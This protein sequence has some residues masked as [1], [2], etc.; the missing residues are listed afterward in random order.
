MTEPTPFSQYL[1]VERAKRGLTGT[2]KT[3]QKT[4]STLTPVEAKAQ[5]ESQDLWGRI[6]SLLSTGLYG[7][8]NTVNQ[9][10]NEMQ[11]QAERQKQGEQT[12]LEDAIGAAGNVLTAKWRGQ[13]AALANAFGTG[14]NPDDMVGGAQLIEKGTDAFG[15]TYNRDYKDETNNVNPVAAGVG[16]FAIDVAADPFTWIPGAQVAKVANLGAR[17]IKA[18]LKIPARLTEEAAIKAENAMAAAGKAGAEV[19]DEASA[20]A[21]PYLKTDVEDIKPTVDETAAAAKVSSDIADATD[22]TIPKSPKAPKVEEAKA[23]AAVDA[24]PSF[25]ELLSGMATTRKGGLTMVQDLG[26]RANE[27]LSGKANKAVPVLLKED[28]WATALT[29]NVEAQIAGRVK[30]GAGAT[31]ATAKLQKLVNDVATNPAARAS[32]YR[33][34]SEGFAEHGGFVDELG[35]KQEGKGPLAWLK[36]ASNSTDQNVAKISVGGSEQV[37]KA[38]DAVAAIS[39]GKIG[40][41]ALSAEQKSS[42]MEQV[43]QAF[44]KATTATDTSV[45]SVAKQ[46]RADLKSR[47]RWYRDTVG[48]KLYAQLAKT[49]DDTK[50]VAVFETLRDVADG[51]KSISKLLTWAQEP[52]AS[53]LKNLFEFLGLPDAVAHNALYRQAVSNVTDEAFKQMTKGAIDAKDYTAMFARAGAS[54]DQ[55]RDM[56]RVLGDWLNERIAMRDLPFLTKKGATAS[57]EL[58]GEGIRFLPS[59][60]NSMDMRDLYRDINKMAAKRA[61]SLRLF[62]KARADAVRLY[63]TEGMA[64]IEHVMDTM[65]FPLWVSTNIPVAQGARRFLLSPTQIMAALN[66]ADSRVANM[67]F[68]NADTKVPFTFVMDAIIRKMN[69]PAAAIDDI[70]DGSADAA[71]WSQLGRSAPNYGGNAFVSGGAYGSAGKAKGK[72]F[73]GE[74][75]SAMFT[76]ALDNSLTDLA[77]LAKAND[78]AF[79]GRWPSESKNLVDQSWERLNALAADPTRI[80]Q[81]LQYTA[82]LMQDAA[83]NGKFAGA[84]DVSIIKAQEQ[85]R[86]LV[87]DASMVFAETSAR[88]ASKAKSSMKKTAKNPK[89]TAKEAD[90][91]AA[92]EAAPEVDKGLEKAID[93]YDANSQAIIDEI[94]ELVNASDEAIASEKALG[95]VNAMEMAQLAPFGRVWAA[96]NSRFNRF[97]EMPHVANTLH[98]AIGYAGQL[99]H[100]YARSLNAIAKS[101]AKVDGDGK[102]VLARVFDDIRKG[103]TPTVGDE[104]AYEQLKALTAMVHDIGGKGSF[105]D[106]PL[107]RT[108]RG[109]E[110]VSSYLERAGLDPI[111]MDLAAKAV[112]DGTYDNLWDAASQQWREAKIADP[113]DYL[114][115]RQSALMGLV[116][117]VS[118]AK[119]FQKFVKENGFISSVKKPGYVSTKGMDGTYFQFLPDDQFINAELVQELQHLSKYAEQSRSMGGPLGDFVN[120]SFLPVQNAWKKAIT[121]YRPGHHIRNLFGTQSIIFLAEGT[122]G[123]APSALAARKILAARNNYEGVDVLKALMD[124]GVKGAGDGSLSLL[125]VGG[126]AYTADQAWRSMNRL[127]LMPTY[128][129]GE[130]I[131]EGVATNKIVKAVEKVSLKDT[132]F[133]KVAGGVS[134]Y[135]D[136]FGRAHQ[137]M[138]ILTQNAKRVGAGKKFKTLEDLEKYA[139]D[140]VK[141]FQ[142]DSSM[143]TPFEAKYLRTAIPFYSWFRGVLPAMMASVVMTPGRFMAFPKASFN[144]AYAMGVNPDSLYDPFPEDQ[145]FPS[146]LTEQIQGPVFDI[147]GSYIGLNPGIASFDVFNTLGQDPIRGIAG[148]TTPLVRA[149][150]E[151]LT[152]SQVSTGARIKD[153]SDYVDSQIPGVNYLSNITGTSAS[154]SLLSLLQGKGFDPQ[155]Q[156]AAG[157]KTVG[158]Q[159]VS[160]VNYL[161]GLG[162]Q[163]MSKPNYIN[164]AEIERRNKAAEASK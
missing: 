104:A 12:T 150:I 112:K 154:G 44:T 89:A 22:V 121:I 142:P 81:A 79:V 159:G 114:M 113:M 24:V 134:E 37:L 83:A 82:N 164:Y 27:L 51:E 101:F 84:F 59:E 109:V 86:K 92:K 73:T 95:R 120:N 151:M 34:Y 155:Y 4:I 88:G 103:N 74:E 156:V 7:M 127:G 68:F 23:A 20:A 116:K 32:L 9:G 124:D 128:H 102:D 131:A 40:K 138:M 117:D 71:Y 139:A 2:P 132:K 144:L 25:D 163:N 118:V 100:E 65:G 129:V 21:H 62:G 10:F 67:L 45:G 141:K 133:E 160:L 15:Q 93:E 97:H 105:M 38:S 35:R 49:T 161:T 148:M 56:S 125:N 99:R 47:E 108:Q 33:R 16:G 126:K 41:E 64:Y 110:T 85:L 140:R 11:K 6:I 66:A 98:E 46:I 50:L 60:L 3:Q 75:I 90:Q 30:T 72:K 69:D 80:G 152:G 53:Q 29:K 137:Y 94:P 55:A 87:P 157:N 61:D 115:R 162:I 43:T 52:S 18:A 48:S 96:F 58:K 122:R 57:N 146:F 153:M 5:P 107:F 28:E 91:A 130:D 143:L 149:P 14:G 135:T 39:T 26:R 63:T 76:N 158:D 119:G 145:L 19:S 8:T 123:Y 136:H 70:L 42:L 147:G 36:E 31:E 78:T 54:A 106:D 17:G 1:A 111:D 77:S 13:G